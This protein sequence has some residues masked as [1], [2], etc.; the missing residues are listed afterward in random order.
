MLIFLCL[1]YLIQII[2][3][4]KWNFKMSEDAWR[5]WKFS[6]IYFFYTSIVSMKMSCFSCSHCSLFISSLDMCVLKCTWAMLR[7]LQWVI[8]SLFTKMKAFTIIKIVFFISTKL[9][10]LVVYFLDYVLCP[11]VQYNLTKFSSVPQKF[12]KFRQ[13]IV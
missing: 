10:S 4:N 3:N 8:R 9:P 1:K 6:C 12:K 13:M 11:L 2:V 7:L 5:N